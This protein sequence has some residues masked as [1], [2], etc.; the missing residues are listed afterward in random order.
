L[1]RA[2]PVFTTHTVLLSLERNW[3]AGGLGE[4]KSGWFCKRELFPWPT[5]C[6]T[7][8]VVEEVC[9]S[10]VCL[11][12]ANL[13]FSSGRKLSWRLQDQTAPVTVDFVTSPARSVAPHVVTAKVWQQLPCGSVSIQDAHFMRKYLP[14]VKVYR[15]VAWATH[16]HL[17]LPVSFTQF[18]FLPAARA[19]ANRF[20][21][22]TVHAPYTPSI[23]GA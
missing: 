1:F 12:C 7:Q 13:K 20:G 5:G 19:T 11:I 3:K 17:S 4:A 23:R 2:D 22:E 8:V 14:L 6:W 9:A 16:L 10:V 15:V 21:N 18:L